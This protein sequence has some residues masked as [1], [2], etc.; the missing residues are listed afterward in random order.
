MRTSYGKE[1]ACP[2]CK[3]TNVET[4]PF[5]YRSLKSKEAGKK[6]L[7]EESLVTAISGLKPRQKERLLQKLTP[8]PEPSKTIPAKAIA[9]MAFLISWIMTSAILADRIGEKKYFILL[10][11]VSFIIVVPFFMIL[12]FIIRDLLREVA[13]Y[14]K[15]KAVWN[16]QY[17]CRDC[18][19]VFIPKD[20]L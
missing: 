11:A 8:P 6:I 12:R 15:I 10:T 3:N 17:F 1:V 16:K 14:R 18:Q 5:L 2:R 4:V 13:R 9:L 7:T 19:D 20:K